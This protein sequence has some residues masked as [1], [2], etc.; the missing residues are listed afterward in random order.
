MTSASHCVPCPMG[1]YSDTPAAWSESACKPCPAGKYL[2]IVGGKAASQCRTCE[3]GK[4]SG[5]LNATDSSYCTPCPVGTYLMSRGGSAVGDCLECSAGT[6]NEVVGA[7]SFNVCKDCPAGRYSNES[8]SSVCVECLAG[9][10]SNSSASTFCYD[11]EAGKYVGAMGRTVC[12]NCAAGKYSKQVRLS[13]DGC[14]ECEI[15]K[16]MPNAGA[17]ACNPC[18]GVAGKTS[19][20][21]GSVDFDECGCAP[22]FS[23]YFDGNKSA[24]DDPDPCYACPAGTYKPYVGDGQCVECYAGTTSGVNDPF[25]ACGQEGWSGTV[26][27]ICQSGESV[28]PTCEVTVVMPEG[29]LG[30]LSLTVDIVETDFSSIDEYIT[31]ISAGSEVIARDLLKSYEN[32]AS[33]QSCGTYRRLLDSIQIPATGLGTAVQADLVTNEQTIVRVVRVRIATSQKVGGNSV[34]GFTLH[35]RVRLQMACP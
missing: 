17:V 10:F 21:P 20:P 23:P 2:D 11:C 8:G 18:P 33:K 9:T 19:S 15:A 35:G 6:Y 22:G 1:K 31:Y 29:Q 24:P 27:A 13:F 26:D 3:E 14:L 7:D 30:N 28:A 4:Y 32:D 25:C 5:T 16:Y 12:I 34:C